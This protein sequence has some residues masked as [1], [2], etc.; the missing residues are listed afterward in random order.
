MLTSPALNR[1]QN[2]SRNL[3]LLSIARQHEF[4]AEQAKDE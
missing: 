1:S 2:V 3:G 4:V